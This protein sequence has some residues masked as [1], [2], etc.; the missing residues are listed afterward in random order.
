MKR[1]MVV[2]VFVLAGTMASGATIRQAGTVT[3]ARDPVCLPG[4]PCGSGTEKT[5]T[6]AKDPFCLPG[7]PCGNG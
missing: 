6:P 2:F 4:Y 7:F 5:V 1:L 3:P